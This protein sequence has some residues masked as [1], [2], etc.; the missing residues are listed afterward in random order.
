LDIN[1]KI[2]HAHPNLGTKEWKKAYNYIKSNEPILKLKLSSQYKSH[3]VKSKESTQ[4]NSIVLNKSSVTKNLKDIAAAKNFS[5]EQYTAEEFKFWEIRVS[6]DTSETNW[7]QKKITCDCPFFQKNYF[8]KHSMGVAVLS[9]F[10]TVPEN[11]KYD[12]HPI[13]KLPKRGRPPKAKAALV[14]QNK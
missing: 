12:C 6:N 1:C 9:K 8:C 2:F 4:V 10:V 14:V 3:F 5:F 11:A 13:S 7:L